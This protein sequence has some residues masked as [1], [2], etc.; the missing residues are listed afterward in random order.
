MPP[1]RAFAVTA[2]PAYALVDGAGP[3]PQGGPTLPRDAPAPRLGTG[4]PA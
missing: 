2:Y 1:A 3:V 4:R